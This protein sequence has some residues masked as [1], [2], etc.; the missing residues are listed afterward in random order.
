MTQDVYMGRRVVAARVA[1][2]GCTGGR[3]RQG[4]SSQNEWI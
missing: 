2:P 4:G 1:G 3:P